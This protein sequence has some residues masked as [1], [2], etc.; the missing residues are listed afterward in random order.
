MKTITGLRKLYK[1]IPLLSV[2]LLAGCK[3]QI[4]EV[5]PA[6]EATYESGRSMQMD[7]Y[8][9]KNGTKFAEVYMPEGNASGIARTI[10]GSRVFYML[11]DQAMIPT[12]YKGEVVA[13]ASKSASLDEVTLERFMDMGYS[14]GIYGGEYDEED[15]Y[16]HISVKQ[17]LCLRSDAQEIFGK[18]VSDEIRIVSVNGDPI[19]EL[20][21]KKSGIIQGLNK[22][23]T[24]LVEFYS[25]TYYYRQKIKADTQFLKAFE[26]SNYGKK[27]IS[28]TKNGYMCFETPQTLRSG[29]Y[30]VNGKGLFLYHDYTREEVRDYESYNESSYMTAEEAIAAYSH[31]YAVNLSKNTKNVVIEVPCLTDLDEDA[32]GKVVA[33]DKTIYEMDV[34]QSTNTMSLTISLAQA[35]EWKVYIPQYIT[36]KE[37]TADSKYMYEDTMCFED[38]YIFDNDMTFQRFQILVYGDGDVYGSLI[39]EGDLRT[40]SFVEDT[41]TTEEKTKQRYLHVEMPYIEAGTYTVKIYY[42]QSSAE[43]GKLEITTYEDTDS[44]IFIIE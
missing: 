39:R 41:Y 30:F 18:V 12:H 35:G 33:P 40:Y 21:D 4:F 27:Y 37:V 9:V 26:V 20:V 16:Y 43:L 31:E 38:T 36:V 6:T 28:D 10:N 42:Y 7:T 25:G 22:D 19:G 14:L 5:A 24:Y 1:L 17:N 34:N 11:E 3:V 44:D 2:I 13:L 32:S 15:N 8:Y 29:Y 23:E